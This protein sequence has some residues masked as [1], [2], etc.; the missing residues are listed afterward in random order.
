MSKL[1]KAFERDN[2]DFEWIHDPEPCTI[3]DIYPY[4]P[5]NI[6]TEDLKFDHDEFCKPWMSKCNPDLIRRFW[7][8]KGSPGKLTLTLY[9]MLFSYVNTCF[10]ELCVHVKGWPRWR[11]R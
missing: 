3:L 5:H 11:I 6:S 7:R 9:G 10:G 2:P 8:S 4:N 1:L